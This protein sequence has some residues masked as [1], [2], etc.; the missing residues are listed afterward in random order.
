MRHTAIKGKSR[1]FNRKQLVASVGLIIGCICL[2]GCFDDVARDNP[3]DPQSDNYQ[4]VGA[5]TGVITNRTLESI[6]AVSVKVES[7]G[8]ASS[9]LYQV[10]TDVSGTYLLEGLPAGEYTLSVEKEGYAS[11]TESLMV[12]VRETLNRGFVLNGLP[13]LDR[14]SARSRHINRVWPPPLDFFAL[15]FSAKA[16]DTDGIL[17]IDA[18]WVEMPSIG[19][20]DTLEFSGSPGEYDSIVLGEEV[21]LSNIHNIIGEQIFFNVSDRFGQVI[22][23]EP[24]QIARVIMDVPNA[25]SPQGG[26]VEQEAQPILV[27]ACQEIS[28][29]YTYTIEVIRTDNVVRNTVT[30]IE[31]LEPDMVCNGQD[32]ASI[33][34]DVGLMQGEYLWTVSIEDNFGN[35]SRS[36]EAGFA[37][38]FDL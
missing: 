3:L 31:N 6:S 25:I 24:V 19:F 14:F 18:L 8:S 23:S 28:F 26:T 10:E 35:T 37:V 9:V 2:S 32:Q 16:D 12:E 29:M 11:Q 17:D 27:W 1:E 15:E 34:V 21:P 30:V 33:Q 36:R 38:R 22:H 7:L 13:F 20:V 5:L 4:P